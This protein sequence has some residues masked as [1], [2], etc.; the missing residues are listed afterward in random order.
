MVKMLEIHT[1]RLENIVHERSQAFYEQKEKVDSLLYSILPKYF[2]PFLTASLR[3]TV[4][5]LSLP[6]S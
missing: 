3:I 1:I 5:E 4:L 2:N 6:D